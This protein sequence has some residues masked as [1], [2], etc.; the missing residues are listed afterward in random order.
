MRLAKLKINITLADYSNT[1]HA[2]DI[3]MLL[4][5][6]AR[7]P[8]GG[9]QPL[10]QHVKDHLIESLSQ[11]PGAFS[12]LCYVDNVAVALLNAFEGFSTF[13]GKPLINIHD[14]VVMERFR[15][16]G[17]AQSLLSKVEEIAKHRGCCK[18]TLEVLEANM[19]ARHAYEKSGFSGY[20]LKPEMGK[21]LFWQKTLD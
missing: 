2:N 4:D 15:G 10:R 18:L 19:P 13:K 16:Q 9:G 1:R 6:Y 8:M 12:L 14:V 17:I 21:A 11:V 5:Y 20:E 7:D 3:L